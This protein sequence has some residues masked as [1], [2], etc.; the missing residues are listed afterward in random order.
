MQ[1]PEVMERA[2]KNQAR[3]EPSYF[4]L[5]LFKPK[6]FKNQASLFKLDPKK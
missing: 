4:G 1:C 6:S 2:S 3:A 5:E